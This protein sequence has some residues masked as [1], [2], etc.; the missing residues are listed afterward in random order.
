MSRLFS[1][2][3]ALLRAVYFE[4]TLEEE[5]Y[6][7]GRQQDQQELLQEK[8]SWMQMISICVPAGGAGADGGGGGD[9]EAGG[10]AGQVRSVGE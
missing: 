7:R 5:Y 6:D 10:G 1:Q 3:P 4:T 9:G 8:V 2:L